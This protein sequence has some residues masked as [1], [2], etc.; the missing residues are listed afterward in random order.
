[1]AQHDSTP[2]KR[3]RLERYGFLLFLGALALLVLLDA[4]SSLLLTPTVTVTIVPITK[5][6]GLTQSINGTSINAHILSPKPVSQSQTIKASGRIHQAAAA[7]HGFLT[8]YNGEFAS[9]AIHA[10]TVLTSEGGVQIATDQSVIVPA[11]S[12]P[13]YGHVTVAAHAMHAGSTGNI[14]SYAIYQQCCYSAMLALNAAAFTGGQDKRDYTIVNKSDV[15]TLV[16]SLSAQLFQVQQVT[17]M[18]QLAPGEALTAVACTP[19]THSNPQV[20]NEATQVTVTVTEQCRGI[21]YDTNALNNS[22]A[23]LLSAKAAQELGS[24][25]SLLGSIQTS[26]QHVTIDHPKRGDIIFQVLMSG[27]WAY[28]INTQQIKTVIVGATQ[29]AATHRLLAQP[30]IQHATVG[31]ITGNQQ[32][33]DDQSHIQLLIRYSTP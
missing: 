20:G 4:L 3:S 32:V 10:G 14:R 21:A 5:A 16:K 26:I 7:A 6:I 28:Q 24:H 30:G 2:Q 31:G 22:V 33:P 25:Y 15:Q 18:S 29:Q 1:M 27:T 9:L 17:M 12:P 11:G 19:T 23:Q 13:L 8:F